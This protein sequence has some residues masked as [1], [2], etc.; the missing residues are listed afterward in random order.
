[1][2]SFRIFGGATHHWRTGLSEVG[3]TYYD[4]FCVSVTL[5]W[6][7]AMI[8]GSH[9]SVLRPF[10]SHKVERFLVDFASAKEAAFLYRNSIGICN[11]FSPM[12]F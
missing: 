9:G 5:A 1:M 2:R 12:V 3:D 7:M 10:T 8:F 4:S 6:L 11:L